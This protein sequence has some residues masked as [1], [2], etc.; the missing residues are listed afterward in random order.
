M[1][2]KIKVFEKE[3]YVLIILSKRLFFQMAKEAHEGS[4]LCVERIKQLL[5]LE[6]H[7]STPDNTQL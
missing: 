5:D 1:F 7:A 2:N 4:N 3:N 6:N